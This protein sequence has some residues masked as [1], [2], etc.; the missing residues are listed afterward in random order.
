MTSGS[1]NCN[2]FAEDQLT[3]FDAVQAVL[4]QQCRYCLK[5]FWEVPVRSTGAYRH[6]L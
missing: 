6:T 2:T 3:T 1:S 4:W 5:L